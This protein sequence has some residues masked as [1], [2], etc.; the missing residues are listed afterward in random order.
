MENMPREMRLGWCLVLG[1]SGVLRCMANVPE[2][3]LEDWGNN[4]DELDGIS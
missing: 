1:M 3:F 4:L 2:D